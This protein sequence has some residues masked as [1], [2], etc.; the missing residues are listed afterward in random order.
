M[1]NRH[2]MGNLFRM[3]GDGA[4]IHQIGH[5]T[6]HEGHGALMPDGRILYDRWEYVDRNFGDAQGLWTSNPDGTNH[7]VYFGNNTPSPGGILDARVLPDGH[8][9][10]ATFSSCHD[11]P[12]GAIALVDR[13][14]GVDARE[15]V[16]RTWPASAI[17]LCMKGN[18]DTFKRVKPK[19]EDPYPLG[20]DH[21]LAVRQV[22]GEEMAIV[23]LDTFG[24]EIVLHAEA[25]GCYDPMPLAP[26]PRPTVIPDRTDLAKR[27][28]AFYIY[29]V[30]M[31]TGMEKVERGAVKWVRVVESPEKRFWTRT[32]WMGSGTQAPGMAWNDFNNKRILGT[33]PVDADG[34]AHFAVPADRF[35]YFQLLDG[36][37]MMVQ[38]MRSGTIS[39]PGETTGCIGCH[40]N[41]LSAMPNSHKTA[42]G[43][44]PSP[45]K[46]WYG[47]PRLFGYPAEVQPVF[48]EHCV[49]CHDFGGKG[50]KKLVLAGDLT[51]AFNV[52]YMELR[53][54]NLVK[55]PGAGPANILPPYSWGSH[56]SRVVE[57]LRKGHN[58]VSLD[59][60]SFD[61]LVT[62]I[63][64]N[65][66]Y[67]PRYASAYPKNLYG[68]SPLDGAQLKRLGTLTGVN[69]NKQSHEPR[70]SFTRPEK[71]PVL[72][73]F[74]STD[75]PKYREALSIIQAGKEM[76][77]QK[78]RADMPGYRLVGIEADRE[79][80]Y[81]RLLCEEREAREAIVAG[82]KKRYQPEPLPEAKP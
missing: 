56:A 48:D 80:K 74:K 73:R 44:P 39:R 60:E 1:C 14:T 3:D 4:N 32:A 61:R 59:P 34:S 13:R 51:L 55:V 57:V 28:G 77:A 30:Y 78:P 10:I 27:E 31:G 82:R 2:I 49:T 45:L 43:R 8:R 40:E 42:I 38:S 53:R 69:L 17:D 50:A 24:N 68:R 76:L 37:G 65:A 67:Y 20:N 5:S 9:F 18:Y 25:P 64:I 46:P 6:L 12:W 19:Y 35:V 52:S 16:I 62:W 41:R 26:R 11:R 81:Q 72:A 7:V 54:K 58:D 22:K 33:A 21:F 71:S 70:L 75:D 15:P 66:P 79:E 36:D 47:E 29:D 63:D 23:L